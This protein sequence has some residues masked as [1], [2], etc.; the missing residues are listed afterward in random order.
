MTSIELLTQDFATFSLV[1]VVVTSFLPQQRKKIMSVQDAIFVLKTVVDTAQTIIENKR[2]IGTLAKLNYDV[3]NLLYETNLRLA[4]L[5]TTKAVVITEDDAEEPE[6]SQESKSS[7]KIALEKVTL[8][9]GTVNNYIDEARSRYP[10]EKK[11]VIALAPAP[12][13]K[14]NKQVKKSAFG[15]APNGMPLQYSVV[16]EELIDPT[17]DSGKALK[18]GDPG[19]IEPVPD[20]ILTTIGKT[21]AAGADLAMAGAA[22]AGETTMAVVSAAGDKMT[23]AKYLALLE[24]ERKSVLNVM[25][26]CESMEQQKTILSAVQ[27]VQGRMSPHKSADHQDL[28]LSAVVLQFPASSPSTR[29]LKGW[30]VNRMNQLRGKDPHP[31][32]RG[33]DYVDGIFDPVRETHTG[34]CAMIP[35]SSMRFQQPL[36]PSVSI[37]VPPPPRCCHTLSQHA[38]PC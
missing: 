6:A 30:A 5:E 13:K 10:Q 24:D 22:V 17:I 32:P 18:P 20:T 33:M 19:Y 12:K 25:Q 9:L 31:F 7:S 35:L 26:A 36:S 27:D 8:S 34:W 2:D 38:S 23:I 3:D 4:E 11:K 1:A 37:P 16:Q 29:G 14:K 21:A 15:L 28:M